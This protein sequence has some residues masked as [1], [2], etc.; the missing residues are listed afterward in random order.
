MY[1]NWS[2]LIT[3]YGDNKILDLNLKQIRKLYPNLKIRI[4]NDC[5]GENPNKYYNHP[6]LLK[7][8]QKYN[9]EL[10]NIMFK[11]KDYSH[12]KIESIV[13]GAWDKIKENYVLIIDN[14]T[15]L[16]NKGL[17]KF[18]NNHFNKN[19]NLSV[20]AERIRYNNT[21]NFWNFKKYQPRCDRFSSWLFILNMKLLN[22]NNIKIGCKNKKEEENVY[23]MQKKYEKEIN[24]KLYG[25]PDDCGN[26]FL[27]IHFSKLDFLDL[28][29]YFIFYCDDRVGIV[30]NIDSISR[31]CKYYYHIGNYSHENKLNQ[32]KIYKRTYDYIINQKYKIFTR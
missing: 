19:K 29:N 16:L 17:I 1:D 5:T 24:T 3:N 14:D 28:N 25:D 32:D 11:D 9:V 30:N 22:N 12:R 7:Y 27:K 2:I 18:A 4:A 23:I 20:I 15:I 10:L 13:Y 8:C 26:L 6:I 31:L 21:K